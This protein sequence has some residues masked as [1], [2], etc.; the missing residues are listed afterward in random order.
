[1]KINT[2]KF[3]NN[4]PNNQQ[5]NK[6]DINRN[7]Q[8]VSATVTSSE[9]VSLKDLKNLLQTVFDF[10]ISGTKR[11]NLSS[12]EIAAIES[13]IRTLALPIDTSP[14]E[15]DI[16][17]FVERISREIREAKELKEQLNYKITLPNVDNKEIEYLERCIKPIEEKM[18]KYP[19][20]SEGILAEATKSAEYEVNNDKITKY[21][22]EINNLVTTHPDFIAGTKFEDEL[23]VEQIS[24]DEDIEKCPKCGATDISPNSKTGELRCNYCRY[25]FPIQAAAKKKIDPSQLYTRIIEHGARDIK[26]STN[27]IIT[28]KCQSCG[29]EIVVNTD[30]TAI[31]RCH[32]CKNFLSIDNKIPNG[33]APDTI[34]P[35]DMPKE[36]AQ[37]HIENFV[38]K[39]KFFAHPEF[40]KNFTTENISG[41][42]FPY[43]VIDKNLHVSMEGVGEHQTRSYLVKVGKHYKRRYDADEY[44]V[45]RDFDLAID[46]LTIEASSD[47]LNI[48]DDTKTTNI[49]NSIM[50]FDTENCVVYNSNYLRGFTAERR[51]TNIEKVKQLADIQT[52]DIARNRCLDT[53][54]YYDRGVCWTNEQTKLRGERW[55]TSYL[56]VWL[57]SFFQ[58]KKNGENKLHYVAVNARTKETMGSVPLHYPK[59]FLVSAIIELIALIL[60]FPI[61]LID[62]ATDEP[63]MIEIALSLAGILYFF[64]IH[65]RYRNDHARH[66]HES[67]TMTEMSNVKQDDQYT[68]KRVQLKSK[69]IE[70]KNDD[71]VNGSLVPTSPRLHKIIG[72]FINL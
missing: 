8:N 72:Q 67:E 11:S 18:K 7:T 25:H 68:R 59:L 34:L 2:N 36:E 60:M 26:A 48:A 33:A 10:S 37:Q 14:V 56:P 21:L 1:M 44:K 43:Y 64:F 52:M 40:S 69:W 6:Q 22:K 65:K 63:A 42:F 41:V 15:P 19:T 23:I 17:K 16:N 3:G 66:F 46:S 71:E 50:P 9:Y 31:A 57:Y 35:F 53:T 29:A 32:W 4:T 47:K 28:I 12:A 62:M 51:D 45:K 39:R 24:N 55:S 38:K 5:Y 54:K 20:I 49:I 30:E 61:L 58:E 70:G 13:R 27:N